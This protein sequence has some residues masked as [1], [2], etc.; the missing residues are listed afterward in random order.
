MSLEGPTGECARR[1][2]GAK[3]SAVALSWFASQDDPRRCPVS[4]SSE[5][6][7]TNERLLSPPSPTRFPQVSASARCPCGVSGVGLLP[8]AGEQQPQSGD[9]VLVV[10]RDGRLE[11]L[12]CA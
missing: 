2:L 12:E 7:L 5:G 10:Q 3:R 4:D 6:A 11:V 1:P 8:D 9:E